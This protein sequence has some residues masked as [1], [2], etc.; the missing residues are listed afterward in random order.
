MKFKFI[1]KIFLIQ[2]TFLIFLTCSEGR[3]KLLRGPVPARGLCIPAIQGR[4]KSQSVVKEYKQKYRDR[5]NYR[6]TVRTAN[7]PGNKETRVLLRD[8]QLHTHTHTHTQ[9]HT[10]TPTHTHRCKKTLTPRIKNVKKRVFFF[11]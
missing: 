9:T 1:H 5:E 8:I 2:E 11:K 7:R 4:V 3:I 6:E 10:H